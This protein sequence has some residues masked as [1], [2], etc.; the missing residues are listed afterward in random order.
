MNI[1][2]EGAPEG[3]PATRFATDTGYTSDLP[4][5]TFQNC[6]QGLYLWDLGLARE[7]IEFHPRPSD[8][9]KLLPKR[10]I[11]RAC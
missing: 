3:A 4:K 6:S 2:F 11:H 8:L 1:V 9:S 10:Y 5:R 7:Y